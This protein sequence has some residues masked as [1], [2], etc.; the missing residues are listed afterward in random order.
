MRSRRIFLATLTLDSVLFLANFLVA[1]WSGSRTV[2]AGSIYAIADLVATALLL[3]GIHL[4]NRPA[5]VLYPFGRG[6]EIFVWS[7]IATLVTLTIAGL[8]ALMTG[9]V[10]LVRPSPVGHLDSALAV[11]M[12]PS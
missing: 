8:A 9:L 11:V 7:F 4:A 6:K 2:L 3:Y 1:L 5:D 10:Q 12:P